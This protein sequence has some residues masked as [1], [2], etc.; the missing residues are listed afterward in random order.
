MTKDFELSHHIDEKEINAYKHIVSQLKHTSIPDNEILANLGLFLT[1]SSLSRVLFFNELYQKQLHHH[2]VIIEFGVRWG[3]TLSLLSSLRSMYEPYNSSRKIIGF[4]TFEGFPS[5]SEQDGQ[6]PKSQVGNYSVPSEYEAALEQL[7]SAQEALA[8]KSNLKKFELVK[9]DVTQSLP[10]Y[11]KGHPETMVSLVYFD[12]DLYEPTRFSLEQILPYCHKNTVFAFDELCYEDFP[13]E[14]LALRE[15]FQ[16]R[17]Y[18]VFRSP[19]SPQQ[20]Y[21]MLK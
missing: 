6:S 8:P 5:V 13:G 20:S 14:T 2:G 15:V 9:G 16:G 17:D 12:L 18:E 10:K 11:L 21:V 1:R 19:Y 4:D 7:L 3:Q